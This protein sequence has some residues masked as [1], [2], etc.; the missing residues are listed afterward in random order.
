M[1]LSDIVL[2]GEPTLEQLATCNGENSSKDHDY[3][4]TIFLS[5]IPMG[6][7]STT[8]WKWGRG[9]D[10]ART[11]LSLPLTHSSTSGGYLDETFSSM[12]SS[13]R[14]C[15]F[16]HCWQ[17]LPSSLLHCLSLPILHSHSNNSHNTCTR[18]RRLGCLL[19]PLWIKWTI[20]F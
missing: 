10:A 11:Q 7:P 5:E 9:N 13:Q 4:S 6:L 8:H 18:P 3:S 12:A 14:K 19:G 1:A 20:A 15:L 17:T 16:L 2:S